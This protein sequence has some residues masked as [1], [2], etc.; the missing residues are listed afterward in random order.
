ME[1]LLDWSMQFMESLS[2][3][4]SLIGIAAFVLTA[5]SLYTIAK[6]RGI[7]KPWLAWVPVLNVWILGSIADQY[8]YVSKGEVKNRRKVLLG[9]NIA[10]AAIM[11]VL[12][13]L[14]I[15]MVVELML[16]AGG[17]LMGWLGMLE[18]GDVDAIMQIADKVFLPAILMALTA[19]PLI[20]V[21]ITSAVYYWIA[22]YDVFLSCDPANS[23][24]YLLAS[25]FGGFVLEGIE[26]IFL[27]IVREKDLGMPPRKDQVIE[28]AQP[29]PEE[30]LN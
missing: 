20:I 13:V 4:T 2:G 11:L 17:T 7:K 6:R 18:S 16:A 14:L 22:M 10:T 5:L 19:L 21:V 25:I 15:W 24:I 3:I 1:W 9:L 12:F 30:E 23:V 29:L 28:E 8:R 26:C 27:M